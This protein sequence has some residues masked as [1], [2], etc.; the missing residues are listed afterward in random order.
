MAHNDVMI[1]LACPQGHV[2]PRLHAWLWQ[3]LP[4]RLG[5]D[6]VIAQIDGEAEVAF[7]NNLLGQRLIDSGYQRLWLVAA[8]LVPY[9]ET[10]TIL[11][12][13]A[14]VAIGLSYML[15]PGDVVLPNV[16]RC[17]DGA[18]LDWDTLVWSEIQSSPFDVD[19]GGSH[20]TIVHR[21]VLEDAEMQ[22]APGAWWRTLRDPRGRRV[23]TDDVD[24]CWRAR[25]AGYIVR[26]Y[27]GALSG[28]L[29]TCDIGGVW[30]AALAHA[31][32]EK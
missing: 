1:G 6:L 14:D 2:P 26:A 30:R 27:P 16:G 15:G 22:L 20:C 24:F 13:G 25:R 31:R 12:A 21:R 32:G 7:A 3:F 11:E 28:H 18:G 5:E 23:V 17:V 10:P 8:D 9:P 29:K 4:A 19:G